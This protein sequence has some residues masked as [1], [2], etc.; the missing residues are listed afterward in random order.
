MAKVEN[1]DPIDFTEI[2]G[3]LHLQFIESIKQDSIPPV[4]GKDGYKA[5][6]VISATHKSAE[7]NRAISLPL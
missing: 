1:L 4:T 5:V 3:R 7:E 6:E 2:W